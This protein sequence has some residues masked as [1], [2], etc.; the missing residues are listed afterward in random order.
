MIGG[1]TQRA[2]G[3]RHFTGGEP[4]IG[5]GLLDDVDKLGALFQEGAVGDDGFGGTAHAGQRFGSQEDAV[6]HALGD[7]I[8]VCGLGTGTVCRQQIAQALEPN[9]RVE[10]RGGFAAGQIGQRQLIEQGAAFL[11]GSGGGRFLR[12]SRRCLEF[13]QRGFQQALLVAVVADTMEVGGLFEKGCRRE[14]PCGRGRTG[15]SGYARTVVAE[16]L[17]A[18]MLPAAGSGPASRRGRLV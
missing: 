10:R 17:P 5:D 7:G 14:R 15:G 12:L 6:E 18:E 2:G 13:G 9:E 11:H 3:R 1:L 16:M 8:A 4:G